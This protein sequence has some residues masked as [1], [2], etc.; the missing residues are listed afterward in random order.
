MDISQGFSFANF[1][2][3]VLISVEKKKY[4]LLWPSRGRGEKQRRIVLFWVNWCL[5]VLK[6]SFA[7]KTYANSSGLYEA[8]SSFK[9]AYTGM[10]YN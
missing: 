2:S 6:S 8:R 7:S 10:M 4:T 5:I 9:S 1:D 3:G